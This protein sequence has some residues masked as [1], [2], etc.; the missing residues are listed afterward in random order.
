MYL[1]IGAARSVF[2]LRGLFIADIDKILDTLTVI[3]GQMY[4]KIGEGRSTFL[5]YLALFKLTWPSLN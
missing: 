4:L 3:R 5:L 1:R 2:S